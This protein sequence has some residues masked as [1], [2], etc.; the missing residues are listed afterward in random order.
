MAYTGRNGRNVVFAWQCRE[1]RKDGPLFGSVTC[2]KWV[3]LQ[4][5]SQNGCVRGGGGGGVQSSFSQ[6]DE[7]NQTNP[8]P[9]I[10]SR[11]WI[12]AQSD[13]DRTVKWSL[14]FISPTATLPERAR[15][16]INQSISWSCDAWF[17]VTQS[18][19]R[20][21]PPSS[22]RGVWSVCPLCDRSRPLTCL[23]KSCLDF[24]DFVWF[25]FQ[26]KKY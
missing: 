12:S 9:W 13:G 8:Y 17:S 5:L 6:V 10:L 7:E 3:F 24:G 25:C 11:H 16:N 2:L 19:I 15:A 20:T 14:C 21:C 23:K 22:H 4:L 18:D 26:F 1:H